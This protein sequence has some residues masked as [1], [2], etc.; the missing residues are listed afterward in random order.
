MEVRGSEN[1]NPF[2]AAIETNS[3]GHPNRGGQLK[4][5]GAAAYNYR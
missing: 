1:M 2:I 4:F 3:Q 5:L